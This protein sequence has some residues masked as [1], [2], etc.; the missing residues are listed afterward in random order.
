MKKWN[1]TVAFPTIIID[2]KDAVFGYDVEE[3]RK[4]I[5]L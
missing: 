3:L 1:K 5:K 4:K 2:G